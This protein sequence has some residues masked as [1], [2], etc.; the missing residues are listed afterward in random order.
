VSARL[1]LSLALV[2]AAAMS[3]TASATTFRGTCSGTAHDAMSA[4]IG[5]VPRV[6]DHEAGGTG[7]CSGTLDGR[8]IKN[9]P[10]SYGATL[11]DTAA[12]CASGNATG[13]RIK[14][15]FGRRQEVVLAVRSLAQFVL[16]GQAR[17]RAPVL[18]LFT[19]FLQAARGRQDPATL[20]RCASASVRDYAI[21]WVV[22]VGKVGGASPM[23][24]P[25]LAAAIGA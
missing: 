3:A 9:V 7:N 21:D 16:V 12:S 20:A 17:D 14:L 2:L 15:R 5:L 1:L 11:H 8:T 22:Q 6:S 23:R 24:A 25:D 4:P 19:A 13:G 10:V 18:A